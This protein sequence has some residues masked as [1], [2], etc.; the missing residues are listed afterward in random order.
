M[1]KVPFPAPLIPSIVIKLYEPLDS[2]IQEKE[3]A[4]V[5]REI[6]PQLTEEVELIPYEQEEEELTVSLSTFRRRGTPDLQPLSHRSS[7][8]N[9][10]ASWAISPNNPRNVRTAWSV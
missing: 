7:E 8:N 2:V 6:L 1:A 9:E 4:Y 5:V 10:R 3:N